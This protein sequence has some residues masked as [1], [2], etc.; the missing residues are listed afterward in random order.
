MERQIELYRTRD[1]AGRRA[2]A[3]LQ[4]KRAEVIL[5]AASVSPVA[6]A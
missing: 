5:A 2:I 6:G 3:G 4:P 1:A